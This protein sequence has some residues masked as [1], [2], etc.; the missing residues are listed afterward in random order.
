MKLKVWH[1]FDVGVVVLNTGLGEK[2]PLEGE[3]EE[4]DREE[5]DGEGTGS[6][7]LSDIKLLGRCKQER[8][9]KIQ[10]NTKK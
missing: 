2:R 6:T 5:P 3:E 4:E 10:Q 7:E 8:K 1:T 9:E